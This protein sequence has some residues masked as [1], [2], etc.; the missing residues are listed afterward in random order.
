MGA[1]R[2]RSSP[3]SVLIVDYGSQYTQLIARRV[4]ECHVYCEVV[5]PWIE[6][7]EVRRLAPSALILSGGPASVLHAEAPQMNE[8]IL[9]LGIPVLGICYGMQ[10]LVQH[11]GGLV[12]SAAESEYGRAELCLDAPGDPLFEGVSS[13]SVVWMS[14][15]DRVVRL[16]EGFESVGNSGNS[17]F[18]AIRHQGRALYGLQFHPE[19]AHTE[20]GPQILANFL[21]RVAGL[22][23]DWSMGAFVSS[24]RV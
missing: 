18:A 11:L 21:E 15:G 23:G 5:P 14:H 9:D 22:S 8:E 10:L 3:R 2:T 24:Q 4:R 6:T 13:T 7:E 20:A 1:P 12:E 16:P 17:P 19:V